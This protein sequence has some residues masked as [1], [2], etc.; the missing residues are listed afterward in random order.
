[1]KTF[2]TGAT[3]LLGPYVIEAFNDTDVV[4]T[5]RRGGDVQCDLTDLDATRQA[6][7]ELQPDAVIHLAALTD[8]DQCERDPGA[9]KRINVDTAANLAATMPVEAQLVYIST[10]QV[11]PGLGGPYRESDTAPVNVY[12]QSKLDGEQAALRHPNSVCL[13][14]NLFGASRT[15]GRGSLSD[16]MAGMLREEKPVTFFEDIFFSPLH[17]RTL[18]GFIRKIVRN[19][20][21]GVFNLG[22]RGGA[23]KSD[24]G[25]MVAEHLGLPTRTVTVGVSTQMPDRAPRPSDMRFD[26]SRI[27]AVL[28][29]EMPTLEEEVRKL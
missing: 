16:F 6:I 9:A 11:Y 23:S 7:E 27:E 29:T 12:G 19:Q 18:S 17:M 8:V 13:R 26:V 1:M 24:F 5:A 22:C 25:F 3:G 4:T 20:L 14:T 2:V 15:D 21:S 10:D 28:G